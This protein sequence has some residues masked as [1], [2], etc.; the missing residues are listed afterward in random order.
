MAKS[1]E[2][3]KGASINSIKEVIFDHANMRV[4]KS[5]EDSY[6]YNRE[7]YERDH[8]LQLDANMV[9]DAIANGNYG[10][11]SDIAKTVQKYNKVSEPQAYWIARAAWENEIDCI[12]SEGVARASFRVPG[13]NKD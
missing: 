7:R 8:A 11:A 2:V 1:Y 5:F 13:Y 4:A 12:F 10:K 9:V 6:Y 3:K